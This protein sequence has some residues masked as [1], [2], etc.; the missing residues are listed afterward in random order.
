[1][2]NRSSPKFLALAAILAAA[3]LT[4]CGQ[5]PAPAPAPVAAPAAPAKPAPLKAAFVYVG[6]VGDAG[7]TYAHDLGRKEA[8]AKLG[9]KV[10]TTFVESVKEGPDSERVIRELATSGN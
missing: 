9:D 4:A 5:K 2:T 1:M 6:P 8:V 7:Y 10:A 3:G